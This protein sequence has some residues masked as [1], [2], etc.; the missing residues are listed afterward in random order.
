[1]KS[2]AFAMPP[3]RSALRR[4]AREQMPASFLATLRDFADTGIRPGPHWADSE[5]LPHDVAVA[6]LLEASRRY[7]GLARPR[8]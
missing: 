8:G 5:A 6:A 3:S 2:T 1:M 4:A 7:F